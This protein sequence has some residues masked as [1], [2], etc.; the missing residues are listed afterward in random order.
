MSWL[1]SSLQCSS[2]QKEYV[3][4]VDFVLGRR[5]PFADVAIAPAGDCGVIAVERGDLGIA[6]VL[7]RKERLPELAAQVRACFD[8]ELPRGPRRGA[9]NGVGFCGLG[10]RAWLAVCEAGDDAFAS[11]L[12][13]Q[14]G[15]FAAVS[16]QSDAYA[17]MRLAGPKV[18]E[19]LAKGVPLDLHAK[20]F[21]VNEVAATVISH[22]GATMWR[23]DD[24]RDGAPMFE[25]AVFR[26]LA[27]SFWH[28]LSA[29]AAEFG[30][31]FAR[32]GPN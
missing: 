20:A 4:V 19:A 21:G 23:V 18:R 31:S 6:T 5:T 12:R 17:V 11:S 25:I 2:I 15:E 16:D 24:G 13:R 22:I 28:W 8:L 14:I 10:P 9:N 7:V 32:A 3:C 1:K 27:T 26:S 30:L 29:S